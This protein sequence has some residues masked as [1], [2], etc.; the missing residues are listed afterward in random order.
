MDWL[1]LI[2]TEEVIEGL[3]QLVALAL[4]TG[5]GLLTKMGVKYLKQKIGQDNLDAFMKQVDYIVRFLEQ[6][7]INIGIENGEMKKEYAVNWLVAKA[8]E[9]GLDMS[10]EEVAVL[11]EAFVHAIKE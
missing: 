3:L 2:F 10:Y 4:A 8:N 1:W 7:G 9:M 6:F 5:L 11:V